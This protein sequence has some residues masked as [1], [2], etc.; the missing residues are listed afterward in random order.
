MTNNKPNEIDKLVSELGLDKH[1]P[2][3]IQQD[4]FMLGVFK[5]GLETL[6]QG[7]MMLKL[8]Y[9]KNHRQAKATSNKRNGFR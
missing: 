3:E 1:I 2:Y 6:M 9:G 7:E 5:K 4:E 8:G